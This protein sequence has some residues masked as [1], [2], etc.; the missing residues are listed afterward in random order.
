MVLVLEGGYNLDVIQDCAE[1]VYR[2]LRALPGNS[3]FDDP[4]FFQDIA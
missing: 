3:V 1:V 2:E 4:E